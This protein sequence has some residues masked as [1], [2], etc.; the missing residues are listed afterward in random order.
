MTVCFRLRQPADGRRHHRC[1]RASR[2]RICR[3]LPCTGGQW[4]A[5]V[6]QGVIRTLNIHPRRRHRDCCRFPGSVRYEHS[7]HTPES[8]RVPLPGQRLAHKWHDHGDRFA[9]HYQQHHVGSSHATTPGSQADSIFILDSYADPA[10]RAPFTS[11]STTIA[12]LFTLSVS[13]PLLAHA[14]KTF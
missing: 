8:Y 3:G 6:S 12:S 2:P 11:S 9:L 1:R 7:A 14:C 5:F 4:Y 13:I 10:D